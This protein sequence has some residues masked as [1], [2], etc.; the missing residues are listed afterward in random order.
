MQKSQHRGFRRGAPESLLPRWALDWR[1]GNLDLGRVPLIPRSGKRLPVLNGVYRRRGQHWAPA[2]LLRA[3]GGW[4]SGRGCLWDQPPP[5]NLGRGLS[6]ASLLDTTAQR[7][8]G[9]RLGEFSASCAT[10]LERALEA[11]PRDFT[12]HLLAPGLTL[13]CILWLS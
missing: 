11:G 6:K 7:R 12:T 2:V 4:V 8:L 13:L 1:S 9:S 3:W 5:R 10:P